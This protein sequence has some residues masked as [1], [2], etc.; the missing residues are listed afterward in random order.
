MI[1]KIDGHIEERKIFGR[2]DGMPANI[3]KGQFRLNDLKPSG[4]DTDIQRPW[5]ERR[6]IEAKLPKER[7][8]H[9]KCATGKFRITI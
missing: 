5:M 6:E 9:G 4:R 7:G 2:V 1:V 8:L 3:A